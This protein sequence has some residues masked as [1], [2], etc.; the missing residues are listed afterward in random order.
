[1]S[2]RFTG[3]R[4]GRFGFDDANRLMDSADKVEAIPSGERRSPFG[5][6]Y[7]FI[8]KLTADLGTSHF[9]PPE[10]S[11]TGYQSFDW[12]AVKIKKGGSGS[13]TIATASIGS[14]LWKPPPSGRAV[15]LAGTA[16]VGD[17]VTLIPIPTEGGEVWFAFVGSTGGTQSAFPLKLDGATEI[18]SGVYQYSARPVVVLS[19]GSVIPNDAFP[20]GNAFNLF[21]LGNGHGQS[22]SFTN[23]DATIEIVGPVTG[24]VVGT[25]GSVSVDGIVYCFDAVPPMEP[26]CNNPLQF[27][28]GNT[29]FALNKGI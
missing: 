13:R 18:A 9:A 25:I 7:P 16:A 17:L 22:L 23:P 12:T 26:A 14:E 5:A 8:A 24:L 4:V 2:K 28:G 11:T 6:R 15:Q 1:M 19:D 21:E 3:G 29:D 10:G 20:A 27:T